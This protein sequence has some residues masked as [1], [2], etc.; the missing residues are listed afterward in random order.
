MSALGKPA[1]AVSPSSR[2]LPVGDVPPLGGQAHAAE[3]TRPAPLHMTGRRTT[4]P[5]GVRGL[6]QTVPGCASGHRTAMDRDWTGV[7]DSPGHDNKC[8][9]LAQ[10]VG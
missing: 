4:K 10:L 5:G 6:L 9:R 1:I 7:F 3:L 2:M 8:V